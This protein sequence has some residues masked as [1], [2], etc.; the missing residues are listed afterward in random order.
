MLARVHMTRELDIGYLMPSSSKLV[1]LFA[2]LKPID[3]GRDDCGCDKDTD[4]QR[5]SLHASANRHSSAATRR[6]VGWPGLFDFRSIHFSTMVG[7]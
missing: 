6:E 4:V 5:L 2:H 1:P 7:V 3:D